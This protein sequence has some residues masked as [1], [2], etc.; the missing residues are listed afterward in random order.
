MFV[1]IFL[2]LLL[3]FFITPDIYI[4]AVYLRQAPMVWRILF[5]LPTVV[6]FLSIVGVYY[7]GSS[8]VYTLI[9]LFI[10]LCIAMP[11]L[12]FMIFSLLSRLLGHWSPTAATI[13][14]VV[15][16]IAVAAV[17]FVAFYGLTF[18]WKKLEVQHIDLYFDHLPAAYDGYRIAHLSDLH[19]GS[20][21]EKTG[22]VEKVVQR[23]NEE[24]PDLVVFTGDLVNTDPH[25]L[26]PYIPVLSKL[27]APDGV[28]SVLGNH[29]YCLYGKPKRWADVR[30][31]GLIVADIER[32]MGW[33][34]LMNDA[35]ILTRDTDRI[36]IVGVENTGKPPFPQT[37]DLQG[38]V[39]GITDY[40]TIKS[41][42]DLFTILL[43][44]DPSHWRMEVLPK[45][46]IPLT[47]SGHTHSAQL[48][49]GN[50]SPSKWMYEEWDGLY[51]SGD[52]K[53]YISQG[54]GGTFPFRF[55]ARPRIVIITL[56][57]NHE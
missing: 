10:L 18:G 19:V 25:E 2:I 5:F 46:H 27:T 52:Q 36:A 20:Y 44:H 23:V 3:L 31:G 11:K 33:R 48:R 21:R 38:A 42:D 54:I 4:L 28:F 41:S 6:S 29:D 9:F 53:L 32:K 43:T 12:V 14:S 34:M 47:L 55:G 22:F 13:T 8:S 26:T 56:R 35:R 57:R 45:T 24:R 17:F 15:G 51:E 1:I 50:W 16:V 49:I 39:K 40:D 30:E 37:G 7:R